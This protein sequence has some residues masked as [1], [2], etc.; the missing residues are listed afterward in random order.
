MA[1]PLSP[2]EGEASNFDIESDWTDDLGADDDD[3]AGDDS[4]DDSLCNMLCTYTHTQK[5]FFNQHW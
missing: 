2:N 3:S 5:E 4:D 1:R